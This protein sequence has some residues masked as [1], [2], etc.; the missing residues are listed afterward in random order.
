MQRFLLRH[1]ENCSKICPVFS[2][3]KL[4]VDGNMKDGEIQ[5]FTDTFKNKYI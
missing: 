3:T 2:D 4:H 5:N 1:L